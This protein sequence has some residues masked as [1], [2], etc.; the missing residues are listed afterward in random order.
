MTQLALPP[1]HRNQQLFSDYFLDHLLPQRADWQALA[2]EAAPVMAQI[3][4]IYDAYTPSNNEAQLEAE[5]ARPVLK[6]LG[7]TF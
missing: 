6:L 5:L 3:K 4:A 2:A 7:H 1:P